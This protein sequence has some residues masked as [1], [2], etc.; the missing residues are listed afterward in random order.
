MKQAKIIEQQNEKIKQL[1]NS[2]SN[3][4]QWT[5]RGNIVSTSPK[6]TKAFF[7][8]SGTSF[9]ETGEF[10][11]NFNAEVQQGKAAVTQSALYLQ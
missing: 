6:Q 11:M 4:Q 2:I 9:Y 3:H 8:E 5:M 10:A 1:E 7:D